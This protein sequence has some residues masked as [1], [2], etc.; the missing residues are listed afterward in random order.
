MSREQFY[1]DAFRRE[2]NKQSRDCYVFDLWPYGDDVDFGVCGSDVKLDDLDNEKFNNL[3]YKTIT[4]EQMIAEIK[5]TLLSAMD[6]QARVPFNNWQTVTPYVLYRL[7]VYGERVVDY[8][9]K[10]LDERVRGYQDTESMREYFKEVGDSVKMY[11]TMEE[12]TIP[13]L[14]ALHFLIVIEAFE[15]FC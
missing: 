8:T 13:Q 4:R 15:N 2:H 14:K 9:E 7:A 11:P 10:E 3:D 1:T 12:M 5:D 6:Y